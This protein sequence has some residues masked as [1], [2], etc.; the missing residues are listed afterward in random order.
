MK[1]LWIY[2]MAA[3][4][5]LPAL[6]S[7]TIEYPASSESGSSARSLIVHGALDLPYVRPLLD[8]FHRRHPDIAL[9]YR[10]FT[11]LS[12]HRRFL[13]DEERADVMISSAMPWQ[14]RLANDGYAQP[15]ETPNASA[16]PAWARWR[17]ELFGF[18]FEP[19]VI[20]YHR[21]LAE[22]FG[23]ITSHADLLQLLE[24]HHQALQ[25][26]V[27]TYDP[28]R[29]GAGYTYAIEEVRLSPRYW[30]LVAAMGRANTRL[31]DTTGEMLD[32][33]AEGR[34]WLGYN[35]LGSYA[36]DV[37]ETNPD[38]KM[39]IP[40]D[41]ALVTQRLAFLPRSAPHPET[42]EVF[43]DYLLS[44]AGQRVIAEQTTLGAVHPALQGPGTAQALRESLG[45]ALRPIRLGPGLLAT[46]DDLKREALLS[47]WRREYHRWLNLP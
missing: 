22:R 1:H 18:T 12:V 41:Y 27:V 40:D 6:G 39:A 17:Q 5:S 3:W 47:H 29:S 38:L 37:V 33:L 32:G 42:A 44:E 8:D 34:F 21:E 2:L 23:P 24:T 26:R 15:L 19:I 9:R 7:D 25:G 30:D 35:L 36:R 10:N 16:W 14:Y 28:A 45:D 31:V 43:L 4:L 11:T 46:L 13:E 20:V